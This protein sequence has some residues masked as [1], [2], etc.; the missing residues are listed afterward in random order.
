M[1]KQV[2]KLL[3]AAGILMVGPGTTSFAS[4][5]TQGSLT[6]VTRLFASQSQ[7]E[8]GGALEIGNHHEVQIDAAGELHNY[9]AIKLIG[10]DHVNSPWSSDVVDGQ[11]STTMAHVFTGTLASTVQGIEAYVINYK[12]EFGRESDVGGIASVIAVDAY[13]DDKTYILL[14]K[15]YGYVNAKIRDNS[16]E[17]SVVFRTANPELIGA[18]ADM[19]DANAVSDHTDD[20]LYAFV[21]ATDGGD[22]D[23]IHMVNESQDEYPMYATLADGQGQWMNAKLVAQKGRIRFFRNQVYW[24]G[25]LLIRNASEVTTVNT[26]GLPTGDV[27]VS[28]QGKLTITSQTNKE[29]NQ[30]THNTSYTENGDNEEHPNVIVRCS[31]NIAGLNPAE[32]APGYLAV[33]EGVIATIPTGKYIRFEEVVEYWPDEVWADRKAR[34]LEEIFVWHLALEEISGID[35]TVV[36]GTFTKPLEGHEGPVTG[37]G[38]TSYGQ[39]VD[40]EWITGQGMTVT[41][42]K[43]FYDTIFTYIRNPIGLFVRTHQLPLLKY[44]P[45]K[46]DSWSVTAVTLCKNDSHP[47]GQLEFKYSSS[48]I[49]MYEKPDGAGEVEIWSTGSVVI[50]GNNYDKI[51]H[52]YQG[53]LDGPPGT[54]DAHTIN[55][56]Q[57]PDDGPYYYHANMNDNKFWMQKEFDINAWRDAAGN[58]LNPENGNTRT[59]TP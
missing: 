46:P 59:L 50:N 6:R 42:E 7:T 58:L 14:D 20:K 8:K 29:D 34:N 38:K 28:D 2:T 19:E 21:L 54:T 26:S 5:P 23:E 13:T 18:I 4:I 15:G 49:S 37:S 3:L 40:T 27:R 44:I 30:G 53:T 32:P 45:E 52:P 10:E 25:E 39:P 35:P 51:W 22:L 36:Y 31:I 41:S 1:K 47:G 24:G 11:Y 16:V 55:H 57:G 43:W 48:G 56:F 12:Y 33:N 17:R 9:G